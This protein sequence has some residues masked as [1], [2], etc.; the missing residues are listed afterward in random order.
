MTDNPIDRRHANRTGIG[1]PV[2][3]QRVGRPA[4]WFLALCSW[5]FFAVFIL[6]HI[7][8]RYMWKALEEG[9][10]L[11][12][13]FLAFHAIVRFLLHNLFLGGVILGPPLAFIWLACMV[14]AVRR[15]KALAIVAVLPA[16]LFFPMLIL[17]D[18][19]K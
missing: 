16:V 3:W 6:D 10:A 5:A 1:C 9:I 19:L 15:G 4:A 18:Y 17:L 12:Q 7:R 14:I 8:G 13:P 2:F 11:T